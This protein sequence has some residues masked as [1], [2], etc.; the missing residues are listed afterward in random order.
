MPKKSGTTVGSNWRRQYD[1]AISAGTASIG[2][3]V[4]GRALGITGRGIE[5]ELPKSVGNTASNNVPDGSGSIDTIGLDG[6]DTLVGTSFPGATVTPDYKAPDYE[7]NSGPIK[8]V[9]SIKNAPVNAAPSEKVAFR[10]V[11]LDPNYEPNSGPIKIIGLSN[12]DPLFTSLVKKTSSEAEPFIR[13][14]EYDTALANDDLG[15]LHSKKE[16]KATIEKAGSP[17]VVYKSRAIDDTS[18]RVGSFLRNPEKSTDDLVLFRF[19]QSIDPRWV[20]RRA[21]PL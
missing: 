20:S 2:F 1:H 21:D 18:D 9:G 11:R 7:P 15:I 8:I 14:T 17:E 19:F 12:E 13:G 4:A 6:G 5:N 3:S 10:P 16:G